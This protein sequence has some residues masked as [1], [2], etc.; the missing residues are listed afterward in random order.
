MYP[1]RLTNFVAFA[2]GKGYVGLVPELNL[3]KLTLKTEEYRGG[4]MDTPVA[5]VTGTEKLEASFTLAEYNAAVL[6]LWGIAP[7]ADKQFVFRGAMQRQGEDAQA[8]VATIG[9]RIKELDPGTWKAGD[10]ASLK[11][12]IAV[13]YYRLTIN[14]A[15]VIEIDVV[16]MKRIINGVDQLASQRAALGI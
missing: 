1:Q 9:G 12:S 7:G 2:D 8:I 4:G 13:T 6:S 10:Q 14:G 5:V 11:V 16:N 15:D 3:P